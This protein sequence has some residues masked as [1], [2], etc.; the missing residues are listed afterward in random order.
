M[1]IIRLATTAPAGSK[2]ASCRV[3]LT[4]PIPASP[5]HPG[6]SGQSHYDR[7]A[8]ERPQKRKGLR[9][10][11]ASIEEISV[12]SRTRCFFTHRQMQLPC[13]WGM[14]QGLCASGEGTDDEGDGGKLAVPQAGGDLCAPRRQWTG[15]SPLSRRA[16]LV[17]KWLTPVGNER[18]R[19]HPRVTVCGSPQLADASRSRSKRRACVSAAARVRRGR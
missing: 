19:S 5:S 8:M 3:R 6:E 2:D 11:L 18:G 7:E 9:R 12:G 17:T 13:G 1:R 16:N 15:Q 14:G 4:R 10:L